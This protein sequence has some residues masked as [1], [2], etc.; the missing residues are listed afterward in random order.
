MKFI[1][2]IAILGAL[3]WTPHLISVIRSYLTKSEVRIITQKTAEI[4]FTSLGPIL[5]MRVAFSVKNHDIVVS[6]FRIRLKHESGEE[7]LFEW[8]GIRQSLGK[9]DTADGPI[10]YEKENSVLA[11]KLNLKEIEERLIQCQEVS[12]ISDK[13]LVE[14][15]AVKRLAF[16]KEKEGFEPF[17]FLKC[18][19][20]SDIYNFIK[21]AFSWKSG[22]YTAEILVESPEKYNLSG[23][24]F[25]FRLTPI[26]IEFL[27]KNK[28]G[29]EQYYRNDLIGAKHD[30]YKDVV[31]NW[32]NPNVTPVA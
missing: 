11:I 18:E 26:D 20:M 19:E 5:N 25:Q 23:N 3:A 21:H 30:K 28:D 9:M 4:G 2:W 31:W 29:I 13:R 17:E 1:D 15:K 16:E 22:L 12:F 6:N 32:R 7:K 24:V 8:Q 27:E 10:P 14:E